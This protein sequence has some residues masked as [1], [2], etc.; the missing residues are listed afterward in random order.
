V[1]G[2]LR[3]SCLNRLHSNLCRWGGTFRLLSH[4]RNWE[5]RRLKRRVRWWMERRGCW[6]RNPLDVLVLQILGCYL[7]RR[8]LRIGDLR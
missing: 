5:A 8:N 2:L 7:N 1:E 6:L 4:L 3:A